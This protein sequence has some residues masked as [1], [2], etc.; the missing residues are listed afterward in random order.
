MK[1]NQ[2]LK[3]YVNMTFTI[4]PERVKPH[5]VKNHNLKDEGVEECKHRHFQPRLW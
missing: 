1:Q 5:L 4:K 3:V 2:C